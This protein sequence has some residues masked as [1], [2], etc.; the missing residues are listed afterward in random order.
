MTGRHET[1]LEL[2]REP[3]DLEQA[4]YFRLQDEP[5]V[6]RLFTRAG[7]FQGLFNLASSEVANSTLDEKLQ[8]VMALEQLFGSEALL[9]ATCAFQERK[10]RSSK[11][12][13]ALF[14]EALRWYEMPESDRQRIR[15]ALGPYLSKGR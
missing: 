15:V 14:R 5:D 9:A 6:L 10:G 3:R 8:A 11:E 13:T 1:H 4:F 12:A 7:G 2:R